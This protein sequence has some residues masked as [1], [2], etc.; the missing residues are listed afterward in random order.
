MT[1]ILNIYPDSELDYNGEG[2]ISDYANQELID[3]GGCYMVTLNSIEE[4]E[5]VKSA[6]N[7][8]PDIPF[9]DF[10]LTSGE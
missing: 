2:L 6:I 1:Y 4:V 8:T 9:C 10:E 7:R 3:L 5:K